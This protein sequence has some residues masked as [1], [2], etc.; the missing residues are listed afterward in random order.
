MTTYD[1]NDL[2]FATKHEDCH[3]CERM[4]VMAYTAFKQLDG[5]SDVSTGDDDH[6]GGVSINNRCTVA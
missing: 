6:S 1:Y 3:E 2:Q 5:W 4:L